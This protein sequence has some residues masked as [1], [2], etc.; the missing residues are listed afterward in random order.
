[1]MLLAQLQQL[2]TRLTEKIEAVSR[3]LALPPPPPL[4]RQTARM[5]QLHANDD[6]EMTEVLSQELSGYEEEEEEEEAQKDTEHKSVDPDD[7]GFAERK[8][9]NVDEPRPKRQ[10]F[11]A[12]HFTFTT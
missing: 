4:Q 11:R 2:E 6:D 9:C 12:E 3:D 10:R 7:N 8:E 1:M 5:E